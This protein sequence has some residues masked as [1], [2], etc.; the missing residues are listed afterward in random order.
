[1]SAS[2]AVKAAVSVT[3]E[4]RAKAFDLLLAK[5][6]LPVVTATSRFESHLTFVAASPG[7]KAVPSRYSSTVVWLNRTTGEI[8]YDGDYRRTLEPVAQ[9]LSRL[10]DETVS[11][12]PVMTR[13][14]EENV[15]FE[16]RLDS[17]DSLGLYAEELSAE[18]TQLLQEIVL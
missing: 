16:V 6:N 10:L 2:V 1:M 4:L 8:S 13:L 14:Q 5:L 3:P 11:L 9:R 15:P 7:T 18:D 12:W 17:D